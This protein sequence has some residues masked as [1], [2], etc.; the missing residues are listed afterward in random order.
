MKHIIVT[1][2]PLRGRLFN[3]PLDRDFEH[4]LISA[5]RYACG[6]MSYI[7]SDT[8]NYIKALLPNLSVWCLSVMSRDIAE[9]SALCD[10]SGGKVK[11][12]MDSDHKAWLDF[13]KDIDAELE[14]RR[15]CG[16]T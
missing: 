5:E 13:K 12:G 4:T 11:M 1:D 3:I 15:K 8:I 7:V 14:R 2:D 10:R 6:R 16:L 9:E